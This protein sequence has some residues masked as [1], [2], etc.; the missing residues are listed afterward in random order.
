MFEDDVILIKGAGDL[1]SGVALR[2]W[3]CGFKL[4]LTEL[5]QPTAIRLSVAFAK[6]IFYGRTTVEEATAC[7]VNTI[8]EVFEQW[9]MNNIP[10]LVDPD[11]GIREG[12]SPKVI[13]DARIAK[14]NLGT[15]IDEAPLVIGL[16][17]GFTAGEDVNA[18]IETNRG[19]YMG[20]VFWQGSA[21]PDSRVPGEVKGIRKDRVVYSPTDGVFHHSKSIGELVRSGDKLGTVNGVAVIAG[22]D[23][24]LRGLI[25]DGVPVQKDLKIGDVD[26][27]AMIDHCFSV[28]EKSLAVGGGVLEAIL[29]WMRTEA[30]IET[31][32]K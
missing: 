8:E 3:R 13:V 15:T 10:V 16:G 26:P 4:V 20:R 22:I 14:R 11:A 25:H 24:V 19:H 28:S 9:Q 27:R 23:G 32:S 18:V 30:Y 5:Q 7:R 6:A 17:P 29:S 31:L 2:L 1:A 21:E 12:L